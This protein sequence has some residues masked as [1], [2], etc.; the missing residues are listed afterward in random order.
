MTRTNNP[1]AAL[2]ELDKAEAEWLLKLL[3]KADQNADAAMLEIVSMPSSD[4]RAM[5]LMAAGTDANMA[6][7]IGA[8]IKKD[9]NK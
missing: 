1:P 4:S 2:L 5:L 9:L 7:A 3:E 6:Q 8:R